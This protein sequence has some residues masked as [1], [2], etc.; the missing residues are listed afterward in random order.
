M[1]GLLAGSVGTPPRAFKLARIGHLDD[2]EGG[3]PLA[4]ERVNSTTRS[5][6]LTPRA[7]HLEAMAAQA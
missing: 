6:F 2:L 1:D 7:V 4:A 5:V 3:T